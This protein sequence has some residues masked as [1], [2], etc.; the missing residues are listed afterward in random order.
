MP[1]V[2]EICGR[3]EEIRDEEMMYDILDICSNCATDRVYPDD[4]YP[5]L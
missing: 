2:C 3:V 1:R 4:D 5:V